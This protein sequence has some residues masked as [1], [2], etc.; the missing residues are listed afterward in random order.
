MLQ[1]RAVAVRQ[2]FRQAAV[3]TPNL[4][5]VGAP[6]CGTT[7]LHNYLAQHDECFMSKVKEPGYFSRDR[8]RE[9]LRAA[10]PAVWTYEWYLSLFADAQPNHLIVGESSTSYLRDEKALSDLSEVIENPRIIAMVRDPV[11]LVISYF[12]YNRFQGWEPAETV[13]EAWDRQDSRCAGEVDSNTANRPDS[14]A[15]RDVA[16]LGQQVQTLFRI[17]PREQVLILISDDLHQSPQ[18]V[19]R[20]VQDFLG[21]TYNAELKFRRD[22]AARASQWA[23]MSDLVRNPPPWLATARDRVKRTAGVRSLG[24]RSLIDAVNSKDESYAIEKDFAVKLRQYYRPDVDLLSEL[25]DQDLV[26]RWWS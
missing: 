19:G 15:Y 8:V 14:I 11:A 10:N 7:S 20:R 13:E 23:V 22:N 12:H 1:A 25:L 24:I 3:R 16:T 4:F 9:D 26:S 2:R 5:I 21:L 6:R 18:T 17:F